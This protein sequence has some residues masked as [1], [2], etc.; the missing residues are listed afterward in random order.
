MRIAEEV[1]E[2]ALDALKEAIDIAIVD[3]SYV[4]SERRRWLADAVAG[5]GLHCQASVHHFVAL[6]LFFCPSKRLLDR[7]IRGFDIG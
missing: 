1:L 4:T 6:D 3:A 5:S 2:D 7:A